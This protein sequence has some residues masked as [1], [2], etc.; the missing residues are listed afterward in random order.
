MNDGFLYIWAINA[1]NGSARLYLSNKCTSY[2]RGI[3]WMGNSL[4][5]VGTR[6]VKVWRVE[7]LST[8]PSKPRFNADGLPVG[9]PASPAPKTLSG[10]NCLLGPLVEA[11]FTCVVGLSEDKAIVCSERGDICLL[12]DSGKTQRLSRVA[13]VGFG[14]QC[15]AIDGEGN[16]A[17]AWFGGK[18]GIARAIA[19]SDLTRPMTPPELPA[20]EANSPLISQDETAKRIVAM[21]CI[22]G[23]LITIDS[24]HGITIAVT[25]AANG[26]STLDPVAREL[27]AHRD[28]VMGVRSLYHPNEVQ[29]DFFTWS[30]G[31]SVL[32]WDLEGQC[33]LSLTIELEQQ[34]DNDNDTRNELVVVRAPSRGEYFVSGDKYG[35][36]RCACHHGSM[37]WIYA[38]NRLG[39]QTAFLGNV[40]STPGHTELKLLTFASMTDETL[41][42]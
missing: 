34:C 13:G 4:I 17:N 2:V 10:R 11:T 30:A 14:V 23:R 31:G 7:A 41:P 35:V 18:N 22:G 28:A 3:A 32:L 5:T 19:L 33:K 36:L 39:L 29:S 40:Q 6:H 1:R 9:T 37:L 15:V 8:S 25:R 21:G 27:P 16:S 20:S 38:Y 24:D 26:V 42:H 12:D